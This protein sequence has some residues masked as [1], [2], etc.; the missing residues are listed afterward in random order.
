MMAI[1]RRS[2][3]G[4]GI[5]PAAAYRVAVKTPNSN[6]IPNASW[7]KMALRFTETILSPGMTA[8]SIILTILVHVLSGLAFLIV[9]SRG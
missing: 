3:G 1:D 7:D 2:R 8:G 6:G 5:R 4:V 9:R